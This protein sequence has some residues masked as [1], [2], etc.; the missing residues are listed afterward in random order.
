MYATFTMDITIDKATIN[1]AIINKILVMFIIITLF[2]MLC[3]LTELGDLVYSM[4]VTIQ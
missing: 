2:S 4:T 1:A 3:Q